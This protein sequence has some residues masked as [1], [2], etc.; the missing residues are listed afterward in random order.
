MRCRQFCARKVTWLLLI[1]S[2]WFAAI[3][4]LQAANWPQWRGPQRNGI[5]GETGLLDQWPEAGPPLAWKRDN[6]GA[7][8]STPAVVGDRLYLLGSEGLEDEFIRALDLSHQGQV[9]WSKRIGKVGEPDQ[10]PSY[11]GARSTPTIDGDR[12]YV[13]GSDGD[14]LCLEAAS[15]ETV[16]QKSLRSDFGGDPGEWAYSESPLIDGDVLVCTPGG[17]EATLIALDKHTGEPVWKCST[18]GEEAGYSSVVISNAAGVKQYVQFLGKGL[19]GVDAATGKP[20]W[21]YER[22]AQ[23]SPANIPTPLVHGDYVYSASGRG[24]GALVKIVQGP[25][26]GLAAE[27]AYFNNN[28]PKAIGGTVLVGPYMYGAG[29]DSLMCIEFETGEVQWRERSLG[30]ASLCVADGD[31]YLHGENGEVALVEAT[32][33]AYRQRGRFT[34]EGGPD[35]GKSKAW[36]YPVVADGKLYI[37]DY[38]TLWCYDVAK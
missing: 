19:I 37:F 5:S 21:R 1:F 9:L 20:L 15:G 12:L 3:E 30:A 24:G 34:P 36:A 31:L 32:P 10:N 27:E 22:T 29:S 26:G 11:P 4:T 14:L 33:Q 23:G 28:L 2:G 6:L 17:K 38:G 13:I 7:G 16:W 8:Y 18:E 35:R 25:D